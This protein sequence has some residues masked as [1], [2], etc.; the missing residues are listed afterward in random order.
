MT[1]R[2]QSNKFSRNSVLPL[3]CITYQNVHD[4]PSD[5]RVII[6]SFDK[7]SVGY[8]NLWKIWETIKRKKLTEPSL[9]G[10]VCNSQWNHFFFSWLAFSWIACHKDFC[11]SSEVNIGNLL[12]LTIYFLKSVL[13]VNERLDPVYTHFS[14]HGNQYFS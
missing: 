5:P 13:F 8:S 6:T 9:A 1:E 11:N 2:E 3:L 10:D 4:L 7:S 14:F 12:H